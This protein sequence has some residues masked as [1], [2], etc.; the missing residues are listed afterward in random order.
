MLCTVKMQIAKYRVE[1]LTGTLGFDGGF[2]I[3]SV[4]HSGG[5]CIFWKSH[6]N[7][8]LRNFI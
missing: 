7:L 1:G 6:V 2:A 5:I 8:G 3:N 4:G